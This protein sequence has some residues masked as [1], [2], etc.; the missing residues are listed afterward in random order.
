[1][2]NLLLK[3][4]SPQAGK[5]YSLLLKFSILNAKEISKKMAIVVN[6]V[7]RN[8]EEL[9]RR[10]LVKKIKSY[11]FKYQP[12]PADEAIAFYITLIKQNFQE[13]FNLAGSDDDKL[14]IKFFQTREDFLKLVEKDILRAKRCINIIISG[15]EVPAELVMAHKKA[16]DKGVRIRRLIQDSSHKNIEMAKN[17]L[18][19]GVEIKS[20]PLINARIVALDG[21]IVYFGSYSAYSQLESVGVRFEYGPLALMM[22]ELF[23]KKWA[24][25]KII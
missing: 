24:D 12:K 8:L 10:G 14:K 2:E 3:T 4:L 18:K 23:E 25:A 15:H 20:I 19:I 11:P 16:V 13:T 21:E 5:I 22:D 1:M 6:T 9:I 7:Y 17:W